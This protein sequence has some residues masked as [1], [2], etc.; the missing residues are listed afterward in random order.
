MIQVFDCDQGTPEWFEARK[1]IPTASEFSTV[2]AEGREGLL[3]ATIMDA[4]VKNGCT[5]EQLAA[6]VKAARARGASPSQARLKYLR[7]LA[8]EIIRG[9]PE[10]EGY[11]SPAMER[12][13]VMEA[14]ARDLYA[15]ARGVE[16]LQIGFVRRRDAGA[17]PDSLI[18]DDG[19]LEI[20]T[21]LAHIQIERLQKNELPTEHKA[22]VHGNLWITERAWWDFVSYS[23]GLPPLIVRVERDEGYIAKLATAIDAFNSELAEVVEKVRKYGLPD[24]MAV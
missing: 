15:F 14:E 19:G 23:P 20:K 22:Q 10:D 1:G 13:R 4:M 17:S 18:A 12:G 6:A 3:P 2:L 16:P 7:T 11:S 24:A 21:A 9:T 5:A 8:G